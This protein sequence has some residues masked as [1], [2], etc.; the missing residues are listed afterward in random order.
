[1]SDPKN[2]APSSFGIAPTNV[3]D[4]RRNSPRY[5]FTAA[6]VVMDVKSHTRMNT[7]ISDLGLQGCYVDTNSPFGLGTVVKIHISNA[8]RTFETSGI[9]VYALANM[10]M[11]LAFDTPA[12]DQLTVL[13]KWLGELSGESPCEFDPSANAMPQRADQSSTE[14]QR[15]VL[16]ELLTTLMHKGTLTNSEGTAL[17]Q[18]L[19]R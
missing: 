11:G 12:P 17:I 1:M 15:A 5:A 13:Q 4:E 8:S 3:V 18:R 19:F 2:G 10:G 7:R 14:N 9:V 16:Q 6:A